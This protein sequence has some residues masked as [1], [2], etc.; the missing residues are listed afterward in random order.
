MKIKG[1]LNQTYSGISLRYTRFN[2]FFLKKEIAQANIERLHVGCGHVLLDDWL[3]VFYETREEYG[4]LIK[5]AKAFVLNYNLLKPWPIKNETIKFIAG[6]H[7]IEH[8][9]LNDGIK[10]LKEAHRVMGNNAVIRLS[11]PDMELYARHYVNGNKEFFNHAKIKEWCTFKNAQT[12][13]EIFVAK[14]YDSGGSHKWFYDFDSL[15]HILELAGFK[16]VRRCGRLEG[17]VPD[18]ELLEP[19]ERELETLYVEANKI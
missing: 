10:F 4:R 13:G 9:D 8:L 2:M 19:A 14:A 6:S 11:C 16:N 7:F 1:I 18:L 5:K 15:K 3:N 17:Q 12:P